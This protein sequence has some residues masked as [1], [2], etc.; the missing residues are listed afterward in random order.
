MVQAA[1]AAVAE[2]AAPFRNSSRP[3]LSSL[4]STN[5]RHAFFSSAKCTGIAGTRTH[6]LRPSAPQFNNGDDGNGSEGERLSRDPTKKGRNELKREAR[7]AVRWGMDLATFSSLQI[8]RLLRAASVER[9]VFDAIMLVKRLDPDVREGRRRQFNYIGRLLRNAQPELMDSLIQAFK[10]GD[11]NRLQALS[12]QETWSIDDNDD[13]REED[14]ENVEKE[15]ESYMEVAARWFDGL[16]C[17][18]P[19]IT[20]EVYSVHTVDFDRQELRRLV[21][22]VQSIREG[23]HEEKGGHAGE[24]TLARAKKPLLRFL[25]SLA[26]KSLDG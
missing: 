7:R 3:W 24:A 1:A 20:G 5:P 21:R 11:I 16:I 22:R 4:F 23:L 9:E 15:G 26:K 8:K 6:S 2:V 14:S 13:D 18:D 25:S 19:S 17:K 10:D 12:C